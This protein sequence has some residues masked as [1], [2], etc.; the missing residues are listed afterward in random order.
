[1]L[2]VSEQNAVQNNIQVISPD[3]HDY[4]CISIHPTKQYMRKYDTALIIGTPKNNTSPSPIVLQLTWI[5]YPDNNHYTIS[6]HPY[7]ASVYPRPTPDASEYAEKI[8]DQDIMIC[9]TDDAPPHDKNAIIPW[10]LCHWRQFINKIK[11]NFVSDLQKHIASYILL[12]S[13]QGRPPHNIM[14]LYQN[15]VTLNHPDDSKIP[16]ETYDFRINAP[17]LTNIFTPIPPD[18]ISLIQQQHDEWCSQE[19]DQETPD[20]LIYQMI[21][22]IYNIILPIKLPK[23]ISQHALIQMHRDTQYMRD[24]VTFPTP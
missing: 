2:H 24:Y 20:E 13:P 14:Y 9:H 5:K 6:L 17:A 19:G 4:Q 1:M 7:Q 3:T 10:L 23:D 22:S 15:E 8:N 16:I 12:E 11:N 21:R 18:A